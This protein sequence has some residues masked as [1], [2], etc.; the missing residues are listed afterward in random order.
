M[1]RLAILQSHAIDEEI[2]NEMLNSKTHLTLKQNSQD[3]EFLLKSERNIPLIRTLL[4]FSKMECDTDISSLSRK[5]AYALC[6]AYEAILGARHS[7]VTTSPAVMRNMVLLKKTH[8]RQ[9]V[10]IIGAPTGGMPTLLNSILNSPLPLLC[11]PAN[12]FVSCDDN[13][14]VK[15]VVSSSKLKEGFKHSVKVVNSH[16]YLQN[17]E[18]QL[19]H[20]LK[21]EDNKPM[22]WLRKPTE[23]DVDGFIVKMELYEKDAR[24]VRS[25]LLSGWLADE[26]NDQDQNRDPVSTLI[27]MRRSNPDNTRIYPCLKCG[28]QVNCARY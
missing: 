18:D 11:P 6:T 7:N 19:G 12:D 14:Q 24:A 25:N 16:I 5:K 8:N 4:G 2:H 27:R 10:Q 1:R 9:L 3:V 21:N 13:L 26:I 17:E 28:G 20:I 23:S 22:N 15:R